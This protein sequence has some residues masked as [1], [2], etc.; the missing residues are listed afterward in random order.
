MYRQTPIRRELYRGWRVHF[1]RPLEDSVERR[2]A[3]SAR[4]PASLIK[5]LAVPCTGLLLACAGPG[6][7]TDTP[8]TPDLRRQ[9]A[10]AAAMPVLHRDDALWLERVTFGLDGSSVAEFQ[11]LGRERFL[12]RQL[13]ARDTALPTPIAAQIGALEVSRADPRQWLA[14]LNAQRKSI[15]A[16]TD[17]PDK[18]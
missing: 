12:E 15:N 14:D 10:T 2:G 3:V 13:N 18:E 11:R 5:A 4:M 6:A 17:G 7:R 8:K 9:V 16:M 1:E